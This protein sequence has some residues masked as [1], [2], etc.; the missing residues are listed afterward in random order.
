MA[1]AAKTEVVSRSALRRQREREQRYQ[2][3]LSSAE[4][5]F[6]AK[7][8]QGTSMEEIADLAEVSVGTLYFYFK[9]K[10]DLLVQLLDGIG[11]RIR[12]VV[13]SAFSR[14]EPSL[15]GFTRA[16][17]A[18]FEEFCLPH[19][20]KLAIVFRESVGRGSMVEASRKEIFEKFIAD[21]LSALLRLAD[22][23]GASYK[24][25]F[26]AEVMAVSIVGM[27]ERVAYN[28]LIWHD[29]TDDLPEIAENAVEFTV[30]GIEKL[31]AK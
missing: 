3:I 18:F 11:F 19:P 20:E 9:N 31:L 13:G 8:Y 10:E 26:S 21:V 14:A 17:L 27:Y 1:E 30:G 12:E 25:R 2:T 24:S 28:Y 23:E 22:K 4:T 15:D 5:L 7:G 29:R 16:G 6:A